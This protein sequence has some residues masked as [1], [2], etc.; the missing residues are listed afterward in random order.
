LGLVVA[1]VDWMLADYLFA[2]FSFVVAGYYYYKNYFSVDPFVDQEDIYFVVVVVVDQEDTVRKAVEDIYFV[3]V[4]DRRDTV[5]KAVEDIYF[6][7]V[8]FDRQNIH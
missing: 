4:V 2:V 7:V 6:V 5:R 8:I 3:V 1:D